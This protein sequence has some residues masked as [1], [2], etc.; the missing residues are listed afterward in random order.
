MCQLRQRRLAPL[1]RCV[2]TLCIVDQVSALLLWIGIVSHSLAVRQEVC[3]GLR[4]WCGTWNLGGAAP[5]AELLSA[6]LPTDVA[7]VY[8]IGTQEAKYDRD[9]ERGIEEWSVALARHLG[10]DF[11]QLASVS[12]WEI[13]LL[14]YARREHCSRIVGVST[15]TKATGIAGIAGNKGAQRAARRTL[16][17]NFAPLTR[18]LC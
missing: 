12:M 16:R 17:Q 15:A 13:G 10:R 5:E 6:W 14:V 7:D 11:Y 1:A 8:A 3:D 9:K 2:H 18:V 4:V